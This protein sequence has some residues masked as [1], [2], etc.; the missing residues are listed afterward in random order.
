MKGVETVSARVI[1]VD[2]LPAHPGAVYIGREQSGRRVRPSFRRSSWANPWNWRKLTGGRAEAVE[3]YRR[4]LAG[5]PAATSR[6]PAGR[7]HKPTAEEIRRELAGKVL[8]CWCSPGEPCH[9]HILGEIADGGI[10]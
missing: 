4:W 7:W 3:L 2:D 1:H 9:G 8:A 6:L 10:G 5:D